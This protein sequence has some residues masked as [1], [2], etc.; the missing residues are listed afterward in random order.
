MLLSLALTVC[1]SQAPAKPKPPPPGSGPTAAETAKLYFLAG[2]IARAQ[3][4]VTRGL[5]RE[6]KTCGP[7]NK[8]IAEYAFLANHVDEFT[9]EQ[10]KSFIDL[11]HQ[12][13]P[14]VRAKLT[15]K[16]YAHYVL[17]P[18]EL[19]RSRMNGDAPGAVDLLNHA[20]VVDPKNADALALLAEIKKQP[21]PDAGR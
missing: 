11:D 19:A 20:L 1:L 18:I 9:P 13:S 10:A 16:A 4:W 12:I 3:D 21:R 17:K 15:E 6:P 8:L 7:L 2:D 14:T 5:K